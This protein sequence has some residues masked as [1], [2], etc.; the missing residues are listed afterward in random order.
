MQQ[1]HN[2]FG[3]FLGNFLRRDK[4]RREKVVYMKREEK[5]SEET[6]R[7]GDKKMR[8]KMWPIKDQKGK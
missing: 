4:M 3:I 8:R 5:G 7:E 1:L 2:I 6:R